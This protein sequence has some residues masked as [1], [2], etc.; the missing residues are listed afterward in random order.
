M[1]SILLSA[2]LALAGL[3]LSSPAGFADRP[4]E[5]LAPWQIWD[6]HR[7]E[8]VA[9]EQWAALLAEQDVIYLGEEHQNQWHIEA[10]LR[11]LRSLVE[12]HHRPAL[13]MEMFTWDGQSALNRYVTD[14]DASREEFLTASKWAA[15]WGGA[16]ED[17]EPLV[18]FARTQR[19]PLLALN[20]PRSLVRAVARQGL[21]A[22]M[23]DSGMAAWHMDRET[24]VEDPDYRAVIMRQLTLCHGG[25]SEEGYGRMYE[26]SVFRD[27]GMAKVIADYVRH[28]T[29]SGE[30]HHPVVSYTGGGHIQH[31]L[32]V[33]SRV[34]RRVPDVRQTTVYL[35][36]VT[37]DRAEEI[38]ALLRET[39][40]DYVWLTPV[41]QQ[42]PPKRCGG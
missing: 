29:S 12:R 35:A 33:P 18:S 17:Y 42:G 4:A 30:R 25:L 3:L 23:A 13:A 27:E 39:I 34:R 40:A 10:A 36:S 16:F 5:A 26:A 8:P 6:T 11:V 31:G 38:E 32:P 21:A 1:W 24:F 14:P 20:P 9:F 41:G 7:R 28:E 19:L 22:A 37:A 2:C 15:G